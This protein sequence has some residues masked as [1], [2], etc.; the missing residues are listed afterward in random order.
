MSQSQ[1]TED[2]GEAYT[3]DQY[4]GVWQPK[5][6]IIQY[7]HAHNRKSTESLPIRSR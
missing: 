4:N 1:Y 2:V 6:W 5:G 7:T 3:N